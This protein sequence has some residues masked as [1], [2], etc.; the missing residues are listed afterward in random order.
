VLGVLA[1]VVPAGLAFSLGAVVG[2][3]EER[4]EDQVCLMGNAGPASDSAAAEADDTFDVT[5]DCSGTAPEA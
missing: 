5:A 2:P 3:V 4:L 1:L